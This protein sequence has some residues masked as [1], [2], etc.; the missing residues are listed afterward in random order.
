[1]KIDC[2]PK[3][4]VRRRFVLAIFAIGSDARLIQFAIRSEMAYSR[5]SAINFISPQRSNAEQNPLVHT[6]IIPQTIYTSSKLQLQRIKLH[7]EIVNLKPVTLTI[8]LLGLLRL[9]PQISVPPGGLGLYL[10]RSRVLCLLLV[11]YQ[12]LS[13]Y[14]IE[15]AL[16]SAYYTRTSSNYCNKTTK[17]QTISLTVLFIFKIKKAHVTGPYFLVRYFPG[18]I[19]RL[20]Q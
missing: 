18:R 14:K 15:T 4:F 7:I 19:C 2:V 16:H 5:F 12:R 13:G 3:D 9:A 8:I 6:F 11:K 17:S 10:A 1:M 20:T